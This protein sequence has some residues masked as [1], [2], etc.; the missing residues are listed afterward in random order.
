MGRGDFS[1]PE[2]EAAAK[3]GLGE[4]MRCRRRP[5]RRASQW[6]RTAAA[7]RRLERAGELRRRL[8]PLLPRRRWRRDLPCSLFD[9]GGAASPAPST[10]GGG[11]PLLFPSGAPELPPGQIRAGHGGGPSISLLAGRP[12]ALRRP[13]PRRSLPRVVESRAAG[14]RWSCVLSRG[15]RSGWARVPAGPRQSP[16]GEAGT[17]ISGS[18]SPIRRRKTACV[19]AE[20][21]GLGGGGLEGACVSRAGCASWRGG[22]GAV[23]HGARAAMEQGRSPGGAVVA[24]GARPSG[25]GG[26]E[27]APVREGRGG[28]G[29]RERREKKWVPLPPQLKPAYQRRGSRTHGFVR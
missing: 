2:A 6:L 13:T 14:A 15:S 20:D 26:R 8:P 12:D 29:R 7:W 19:E 9:G 23:V 3:S 11:R 1:C 22:A 24:G 25:E 5:A 21:D 27:A 28:G 16:S 10:T 4:P 17:S 18:T